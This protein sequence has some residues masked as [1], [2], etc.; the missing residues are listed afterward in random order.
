MIQLNFAPILERHIRT[1]TIN[2]AAEDL[3]QAFNLAFQA[4]P[5]LK[6]Y[7][8]DDQNRIRQHV[9]IFI[10]GS[11]LKDRLDW[12]RPLANNDEIYIMQA[13]SGG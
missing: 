3:F 12:N 8:L 5:N 11:L 4:Y 7:I 2:L 6:H 13:L 1:S 9:A 10:N